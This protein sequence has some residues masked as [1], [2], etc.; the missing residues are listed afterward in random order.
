M[1]IIYYPAASI[2]PQPCQPLPR[3]PHLSYTWVSVLPK[4]EEFLVMFYG[5]SIGHSSGLRCKVA[6]SSTQSSSSH[7]IPCLPGTFRV[8]PA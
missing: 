2:T 1:C 6:S 5:L 4:V 8:G 3:I 7:I